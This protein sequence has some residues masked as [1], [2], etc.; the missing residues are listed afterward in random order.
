MIA[1]SNLLK[2][3]I[4]HFKSRWR[5]K[6]IFLDH[7]GEAMYISVI[8]VQWYCGQNEF[9]FNSLISNHSIMITYISYEIIS[10]TYLPKL[11]NIAPI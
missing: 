11:I 8:D 6:D 5:V 10:T 9:V 7:R 3:S 4:Q 1:K 2:S